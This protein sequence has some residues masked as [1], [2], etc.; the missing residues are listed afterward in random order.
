LTSQL[1]IK[2]WSKIMTNISV[3]PSVKCVTVRRFVGVDVEVC[4]TVHTK[5]VIYRNVNVEVHTSDNVTT[6][7][8]QIIERT[9][10]MGDN[11]GKV[12]AAYTNAYYVSI[13]PTCRQTE[14]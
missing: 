4:R 13:N 1:Q 3:H 12:F 5:S 11:E 6:E 8:V 2:N 9:D 7:T 10:I 14:R